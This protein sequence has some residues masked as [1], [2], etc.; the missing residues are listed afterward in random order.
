MQTCTHHI[1]CWQLMLIICK[2]LHTVYFLEITILE[3]STRKHHMLWNNH[4]ISLL[5]HEN[6]FG[7][8]KPISYANQ[9]ISL[10]NI[11]PC[12]ALHA[13]EFEIEI[14]NWEVNLK[15]KVNFLSSIYCL[16]I[17][18]CLPGRT[19]IDAESNNHHQPE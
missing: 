18:R 7:Y 17:K 13:T 9:F 6:V 16:S 15:G 8:F 12:Q 2:N 10:V 4:W 14:N 3:V 11:K 5:I 19:L 1:I